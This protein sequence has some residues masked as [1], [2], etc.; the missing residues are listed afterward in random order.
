MLKKR[1]KGMGHVNKRSTKSYTEQQKSDTTICPN[2]SMPV[3]SP[4][5][6][7]I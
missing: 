4:K 1:K 6:N 7:E 3:H 2:E 5:V